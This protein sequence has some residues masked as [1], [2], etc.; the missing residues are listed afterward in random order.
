MKDTK[1]IIIIIISIVIILGISILLFIQY[2]NKISSSN[3]LLD[4][5]NIKS[6][7]DDNIE[8]KD[9]ML[10]P[11]NIIGYPNLRKAYV[12]C[13]LNSALQMIKTF[14]IYY[15]E[16]TEKDNI[17]IPQEI[18]YFLNYINETKRDK[19]VHSM[20]K[21]LIPDKNTRLNS[22][23]INKRLHQ[24]DSSEFLLYFLQY[25]FSFDKEY[26][27][28]FQYN[29]I[30]TLQSTINPDIISTRTEAESS[31]VINNINQY[32]NQN[33]TNLSTIL[34]D[35]I[36]QPNQDILNYTFTDNDNNIILNDPTT[37]KT[38]YYSN[39]S[40]FLLIILNIFEVDMNINPPAIKKINFYTEI[41]D[42]VT[43]TT[44]N[45]IVYNY[46]PIS[47]ICH[48]G[49]ALPTSGHY[50]NYSKNSLN[51]KWYLY[52]DINVYEV[53]DKLPNKSIIKNNYNP[54]VVLLKRV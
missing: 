10:D 13:Y 22:F 33:I 47:I 6:I 32:K 26:K 34:Q 29:L 51:D 39:F 28:N 43:F 23:Y 8:W 12:V 4:V 52:N 20:L 27:L 14:F 35:L 37:V 17:M 25:L 45:S 40:N 53:T 7:L 44:P 21:L 54:F 48:S 24:S 46:S 16:M 30:S 3:P 9:N 2:N 11:T 38:T 36:G 1:K 42:L 15:L 5:N 18:I 49:G 31:F 41:P 50:V 19:A